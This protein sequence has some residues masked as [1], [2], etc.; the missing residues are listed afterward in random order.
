MTI[1]TYQKMA[2]VG[3]HVEKLEDLY[4]I[5]GSMKWHSHYKKQMDPQKLKQN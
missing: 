4:N 5:G 3:K 1:K 2:S